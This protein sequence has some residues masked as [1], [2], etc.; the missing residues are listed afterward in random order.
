MPRPFDVMVVWSII[1]LGST[2][3][4]LVDTLTDL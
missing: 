3:G 4:G 2:F 1:R